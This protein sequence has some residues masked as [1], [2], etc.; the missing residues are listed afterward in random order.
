MIFNVFYFASHCNAG[1]EANLNMID[2]TAAWP[3]KCVFFCF[4]FL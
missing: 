4:V 1:L 2:L 3:C